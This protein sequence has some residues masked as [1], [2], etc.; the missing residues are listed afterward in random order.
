[1]FNLLINKTNEFNAEIANIA[2]AHNLIY[3]AGTF[4]SENTD[5]ANYSSE[6]T[7][8]ENAIETDL[9]IASMSFSAILLDTLE[10]NRGSD[11]ADLIL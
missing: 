2:E 6:V 9:G 5:K 4:I 1:M 3:I 10:E 7:V 8:T 11:E